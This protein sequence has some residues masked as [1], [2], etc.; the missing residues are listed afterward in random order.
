[1][2]NR[3]RVIISVTTIETTYDRI[4]KIK[5]AAEDKDKPLARCKDCPRFKLIPL[6]CSDEACIKLQAS[7]QPKLE[8]LRPQ[9]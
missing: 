5:L 1:M 2:I 6:V 4:M 9:A 8:T 3:K 7:E